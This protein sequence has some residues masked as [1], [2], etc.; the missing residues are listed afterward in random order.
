MLKKYPNA[1]HGKADNKYVPV[2]F[3]PRQI[4]FHIVT[5]KKTNGGQ[6]EDYLQYCQ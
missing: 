3:L 5:Y 2:F 1:T 4:I 6:Q